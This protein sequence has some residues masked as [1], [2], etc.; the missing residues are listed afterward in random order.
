MLD[1]IVRLRPTEK[2]VHDPSNSPTEWAY[3]LPHRSATG[4]KIAFFLARIAAPDS[5]GNW[6]VCG[7]TQADL[8]AE[9]GITDRALRIHL[10]HLEEAGWLR[11][12]LRGRSS[13]SGLDYILVVPNGAEVDR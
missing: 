13:A 5:N 9:I 6:A 2:P 12:Q 3:A 10:Q 4:H 7:R 11:R 8:A 1:A